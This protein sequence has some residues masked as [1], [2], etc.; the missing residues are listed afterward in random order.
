LV[1]IF[2]DTWPKYLS[3]S[4]SS[5]SLPNFKHLGDKPLLQRLFFQQIASERR[6]FLVKNDVWLEPIQRV[7]P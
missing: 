3:I 6:F 2:I 5:K 4:T 1:A 7:N